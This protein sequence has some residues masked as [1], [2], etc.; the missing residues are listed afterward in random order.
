MDIRN[1]SDYNE[2]GYDR[3]TELE[4]YLIL[5]DVE[6]KLAMDW[7]RC[8]S[9]ILENCMSEGNTTIIPESGDEEML[10]RASFTDENGQEHKTRISCKN[11]RE[12]QAKRDAWKKAEEA[13]VDQKDALPTV[14]DCAVQYQRS[15]KFLQKSPTTRAQ[16]TFEFENYIKPYIGDLALE[17]VGLDSIQCM[18]DSLAKR[19]LSKSTINRALSTGRMIF[20]YAVA[21]R[22]VSRN[23][24]NECKF[25]LVNE[26]R[27]NGNH[28][29]MTQEEFFTVC[30]EVLSLENLQEQM[31]L[32]FTLFLGMRREEALGMKWEDLR[33]W[34]ENKY[35]HIHRTVVFPGH[36]QTIR[37]D[38]AKSKGSLMRPFSVHDVA[39]GI[40]TAADVDQRTGWIFPSKAKKASGNPMNE[41]EVDK[42]MKDSLAC[43]GIHGY[44]NH[45]MR[46]TFGTMCSEIGNLSPEVIA[47]CLGHSDV[48]TTKKIYIQESDAV[49]T[50]R[51]R[52]GLNRTFQHAAC[53]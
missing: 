51:T 36:K 29:P 44:S 42:L 18:V 10:K 3:L 53:V 12:Y 46:T 6:K 24:F 5:Q 33:G 38:Q 34:Q 25:L 8:Y 50:E 7:G 23:P 9:M 16:D 37:E 20:A 2:T 11:E 48:K 17:K 22:Y 52:N 43:L 49:K 27:E 1:F 41:H 28:K 31:W 26:G 35:F 13:K 45:D 14:T 19:A 15:R 4:K 39:A 30:K 21:N 40:L 32:C 47:N